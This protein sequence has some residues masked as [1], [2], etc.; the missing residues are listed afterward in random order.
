MLELLSGVDVFW[1]RRA[2]ASPSSMN[3]SGHATSYWLL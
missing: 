1:L 2:V 3:V